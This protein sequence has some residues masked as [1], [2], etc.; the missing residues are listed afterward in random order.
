[1]WNC[2]WLNKLPRWSYMDLLFRN[3]NYYFRGYVYK[4][5]LLR[6]YA[7]VFKI[8]FQQ[9]WIKVEVYS[10]LPI[11]TSVEFTGLKLL[12]VDIRVHRSVLPAFVLII[13]R[14]PITREETCGSVLLTSCCLP[15]FLQLLSN[16]NADFHLSLWSTIQ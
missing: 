3:S 5:S 7:T 14:L 9:I 4:W 10:W 11:I 15:S 12:F 2:S 8:L 13:P 16:W 1:M 6:T